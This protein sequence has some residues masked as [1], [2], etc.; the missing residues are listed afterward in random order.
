MKKLF[1]PIPAHL[2]TELCT[3]PNQAG[4][5]S[6]LNKTCAGDAFSNAPERHVLLKSS[7]AYCYF[8]GEL[9]D[10]ELHDF[11]QFLKTFPMVKLLCQES[12]HTHLLIEG[13]KAC[14]R[15]DLIYQN[16]SIEIKDLLPFL[17][18]PITSSKLGRKCPW[19]SFIIGL[20]GSEEMFFKNGF[21]V[22]LCREDNVLCATYAAYVGGGYAEIG[23]VTSPGHEGKGLATLAG[24]YCVQECLK[25][26]LI[27]EWSCNFDNPASL[28]VAL[29]AGF[30]LTR[31]YA[32]LL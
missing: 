19:W 29:K 21:G 1:S 12:L 26:R 18:K 4:I 23:I 20:Y 17:V 14:V 27:P 3:L 10:S 31:Y 22:A 11:V 8:A 9:L 6:L 5:H 32:F 28:R 24:K 16:S 15:I 13:M 2:L 7:E 25:R 30:T